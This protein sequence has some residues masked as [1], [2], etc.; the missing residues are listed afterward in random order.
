VLSLSTWISWF[1]S[2]KMH[3][4]PKSW[5]PSSSMNNFKLAL[6]FGISVMVI[7]YALVI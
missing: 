5:I 2:G 1:V 6:Q 7:A 3:T 4:F